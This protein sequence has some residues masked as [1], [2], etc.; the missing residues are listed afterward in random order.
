MLGMENELIID[1][2][3]KLLISAEEIGICTGWHKSM[4]IVVQ[5]K[6]NIIIKNNTRINPVFCVLTTHPV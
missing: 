4:L 3:L 2:A 1:P 5:M 6:N